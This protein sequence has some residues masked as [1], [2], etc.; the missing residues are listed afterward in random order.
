MEI[1]L[2][3]LCNQ[4]MPATIISHA[5]KIKKDEEINIISD[6]EGNQT[7]FVGDFKN[8]HL[9]I[10]VSCTKFKVLSDSIKIPNRREKFFTATVRYFDVIRNEYTDST[11]TFESPLTRQLTNKLTGEIMDCLCDIKIHP[12]YFSD[13][14]HNNINTEA[15]GFSFEYYENNQKIIKKI[16][17]DL[18]F[19]G[20]C[21]NPN[22]LLPLFV[23]YIGIAENFG[24]RDAIERLSNG[25][26]HL[27]NINARLSKKY[28]NKECYACFYRL[29]ED[30]SK[31]CDF[32][33]TVK[34]LE[35]TLI[36][37]FKPLENGQMLNF[38]KNR[39]IDLIQKIRNA[40]IE[41]ILVELHPPKN[42]IFISNAISYP[43]NLD[44]DSCVHSIQIDI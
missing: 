23:E 7:Y 30:F 44:N 38:P 32:T 11:F 36:Q 16:S 41:K 21:I 20:Y 13:N 34:T 2:K 5:K 42:C 8:F 39:N 12:A 31:I 18:P 22:S 14:E 9:Y 3:C 27:N 37:H 26:E 10:L 43:N 28:P 19:F 15:D 4:V 29:E 6:R 24:E 40:S 17:L 33:T 1:L 25:H 35:A